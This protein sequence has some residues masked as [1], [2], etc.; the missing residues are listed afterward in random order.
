EFDVSVQFSFRSLLL[1]DAN[2]SFLY[3]ARKLNEALVGSFACDFSEDFS[4]WV[5]SPVYSVSKPHQPSSS[6]QLVSYPR[7]CAFRFFNIFQHL[8]NW[9][10]GA[11]VQRAFQGS[12]GS[13]YGRVHI[14]PG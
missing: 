10:R 4:P 3:L 12:D 13:R 8:E 5:R 14:R 2:S 11:A 7:L 1:Q 9:C 6:L